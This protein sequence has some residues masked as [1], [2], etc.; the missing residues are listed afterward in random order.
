MGWDGRVRGVRAGGWFPWV[1][2]SARYVSRLWRAERALGRGDGAERGVRGNRGHLGCV[3]S[4]CHPPRYLQA[5]FGFGTGPET[6]R[7]APAH[8]GAA[9]CGRSTLAA[10]VGCGARCRT[11]PRSG[12]RARYLHF[13]STSYCKLLADPG[14][15]FTGHDS[16]SFYSG[17]DGGW[18]SFFYLHKGSNCL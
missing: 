18:S 12:P 14:D 15:A 5:S 16:V 3:G 6:R 13:A 8:A 1:L 4:G 11:R 9:L 10:R 17:L 7:A 2:G